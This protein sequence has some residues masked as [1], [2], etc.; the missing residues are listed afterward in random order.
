MYVLS[1]KPRNKETIN[2][3]LMCEPE[4]SFQSFQVRIT[5]LLQHWVATC[6]N[7][8]A[9][10]LYPL[11]ITSTFFK[12]VLTAGKLESVLIERNC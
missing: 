11:E 8:S 12:Y 9:D 1:Q 2:S 3:G 6:S 5:R 10:Y 4:I 7:C